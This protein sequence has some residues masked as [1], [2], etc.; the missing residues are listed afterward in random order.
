MARELPLEEIK[1]LVGSEVCVT[2]WK[3]IDQDRINTFAD[4]IETHHWI[5][6]DPEKAARGPFGKTVVYGFLILSYIHFFNRDSVAPEKAKV[7]INYGLNKVRFIN[8]VLVDAQIRDRIVLSKVEEQT[9][10]K[11]L[12]TTV[13]TMEIKGQ[14]KP[15]C[16]AES[17]MLY[18]V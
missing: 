1:K 11:I 3:V 12:L 15:A 7:I 17:L 16:V 13:H 14:E 5:H 2:D 9:G 8:P 10:G 6:E 4:C 18:F